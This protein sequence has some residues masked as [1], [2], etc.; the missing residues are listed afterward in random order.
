MKSSPSREQH[1]AQSLLDWHQDHPRPLP[2][3]GKGP[4]E[5]LLSE[6]ILQQTRVEQGL[7]YYLR[8]VTLFPTVF[9]LAQASEDE[10]LHAWQGLGYYTRARNLHRIAKTIVDEL[11]GQ[12][13]ETY[14]GWLALK[15]IGPYTAAAISSFAYDQPYAVVD[16][17][18]YRVLSRLYTPAADFYTSSGKKTYQ[19]LAQRLL[20]PGQAAIFN[21]GIM[22][23]GALQCVPRQPDCTICP[24][25][26]HCKAFKNGKVNAYPPT[27]PLLSKRHR[28][29]HYLVAIDQSGMTWID[30]RKEKDIWQHLYQ[31]PLL[32]TESSV[33]SRDIQK[34]FLKNY[35][36]KDWNTGI[37]SKVYK[38]VLSH[39]VIHACFH[40]LEVREL[41]QHPA[42]ECVKVKNL[43][44][45]AFPKV[46][47]CYLMDYSIYL[48][49]IH[50]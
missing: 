38:H 17:N 46:V 4:Y 9:A 26:T 31:F 24:L 27:K 15:G 6:I 44:N 40:I 7:P 35:Q 42:F 29:F 30:Q 2:W 45:F 48:N 39:Q 8:F 16:G 1:I 50:Q 25:N 10:V 32:E 28:F 19:D 20:P 36:L 18:V 43:P 22:N 14:E 34:L 41:P 21:Q 37:T 13:P 33:D 5:T 23:F 47:H 3:K 11:Q 49:A 12:F